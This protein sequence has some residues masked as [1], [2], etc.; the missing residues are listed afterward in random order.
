MLRDRLTAMALCLGVGLEC[1]TGSA[2]AAP[3]V[4]DAFAPAV[5]F[6]VPPAPSG[7]PAAGGSLPTLESTL[8]GVPPA[9]P[10]DPAGNLPHWATFPPTGPA[11]PPGVGPCD[12]PCPDGTWFG[13]GSDHWSWR[14]F[15]YFRPRCFCPTTGDWYPH[16]AYLP[17]FHG[18]YYYKPYNFTHVLRDM[19]RDQVL[20]E[21]PFMPY[22]TLM[23]AEV[24]HDAENAAY[25][26]FGPPEPTVRPLSPVSK[27]LPDLE[28]LLRMPR[29]T[30]PPPPAGMPFPPPVGGMPFPP[31]GPPLPPIEQAPT[32][33][34]L[35]PLP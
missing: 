12:G 27:P 19:R 24:Y 2:S 7:S 29:V 35:P 8:P 17:A 5:D 21:I 10:A 22:S 4:A 23:F 33:T 26:P 32:P 34:P 14:Y 9:P 13:Y 30:P 18:Y 3:V 20:G 31:V 25:V 11:L 15:G 16:F 6:P 1:L 28:V